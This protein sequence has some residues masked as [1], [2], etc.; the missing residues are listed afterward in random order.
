MQLTKKLIQIA[1]ATMI[2]GVAFAQAGSESKV[3]AENLKQNQAGMHA[4]VN[5]KPVAQRN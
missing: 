4:D 2:S 1:V 5:A 3:S